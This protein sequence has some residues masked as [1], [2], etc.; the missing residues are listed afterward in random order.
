MVFLN[1]S[2]FFSFRRVQSILFLLN[3]FQHCDYTHNVYPC[4]VIIHTII[5][6]LGT[7]WYFITV[8]FQ[9]HFRNTYTEPIL[10]QD[11]EC[12]IYVNSCHI[13]IVLESWYSEMLWNFSSGTQLNA[14]WR[15]HLKPSS[16]LPRG[17][18]YKAYL[19]NTCHIFTS[20]FIIVSSTLSWDLVSLWVSLIPLSLEHS[21]P[22]PQ[23][24]PPAFPAC[25]SYS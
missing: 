9:N 18:V 5:P 24:S 8:L 11:T 19:V 17:L 25:L 22:S 12:F 15:W 10:C 1:A 4:F 21:L 23:L 16:L 7:I 13:H 6:A 14:W 3:N 20:T 2:L